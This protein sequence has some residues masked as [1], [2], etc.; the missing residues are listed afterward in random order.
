MAAKLDECDRLYLRLAVDLSCGFVHDERRWP[1]AALLVVDDQ[2]VGQGVNRVVEL[3]DATAHAEVLALRSAGAR[4][5][6]YHF[7]D[8]VLYASSEPCPMCLTACYWACLPRVVFG[9][10]S[11]DVAAHGLQD[12]QFYAELARPAARR[13]IREDGGDGDLRQDATAILHDWARCFRPRP[14][15]EG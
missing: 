14:G 1:F 3:H 9:A 8:G 12:L 13:S 10:T 11:H 5:G 6:R 2:I 7:E 4:L 15:Q